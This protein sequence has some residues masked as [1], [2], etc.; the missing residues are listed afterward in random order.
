MPYRPP[1]VAHEYF[2]ADPPELV[3]RARGEAGAHLVGRAEITSVDRGEVSLKALTTAGSVL[4]AQVA[5]AGEGI[6]R[7]RLGDDPAARP[8][9]TRAIEL[10]R[11]GHCPDVTVVMTATTVTVTAASLRAEITLDPWRIRFYDN[12]S[13]RL[14]VETEPG[15]VDISG[16]LRTLPFGWSPGEAYHE[17]FALPAQEVLVGTGERF[18]PLNLRG[19]RPVIWNFDAFGSEGD[20]A[21]KNVP[22]YQS[23]NGYGLLV[24]SGAPVEFDFGA[25]T[26]SVVQLF[27]PDDVLDYYVLAGPT[28]GAVL[29]RY[30][31]LTGRPV[32]P[33]KWAFGCLDLLRLLPRYAGGGPGSR[34]DH[35]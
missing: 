23:S 29:D 13:G 17:T 33:P 3:R 26:Q 32:C 15:V 16:R 6:I 10:T 1:L 5:A 8:R 4:H 34:G 19:Q 21:Y 35:P 18:L 28:P 20:R 14:L 7:V 30:D 11:P 22:F 31:Q 9:C 12:A 24:N 25:S 2:V 27:V